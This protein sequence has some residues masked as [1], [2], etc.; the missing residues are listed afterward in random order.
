MTSGDVLTSVKLNPPV[1]GDLTFICQCLS[2]I[3]VIK[4]CYHDNS[5][6]SNVIW[7]HVF[8]L[9]QRDPGYVPHEIGLATRI[10]LNKRNSFTLVS[11]YHGSLLH[12][13]I[14]SVIT[15]WQEIH[16]PV[17]LDCDNVSDCQPS[18]FQNKHSKSSIWRVCFLFQ[19]NNV[20]CHYSNDLCMCVNKHMYC[21][22]ICIWNTYIDMQ[23]I[24]SIIPPI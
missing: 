2:I 20:Q 6:E 11:V 18:D 7:N 4:F 8:V 5:Y 17:T 13:S 14:D 23:I 3:M 9:K 10:I 16:T 12:R 19:L 22:Q 21:I 24:T 15:D 1:K